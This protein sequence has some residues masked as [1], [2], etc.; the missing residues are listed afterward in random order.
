M[1]VITNVL[2]LLLTTALVAKAQKSTKADDRQCQEHLRKL[3]SAVDAFKKDNKGKLP[4]L[5]S[6]LYPK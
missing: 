6:D 1:K 4:R 3:F 2:L 5:M